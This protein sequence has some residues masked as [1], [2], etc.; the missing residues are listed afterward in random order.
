[1]CLSLSLYIYIYI[2]IGCTPALTWLINNHWILPCPTVSDPRTPAVINIKAD[3]DAKLS[4][5]SIASLTG[6][7]SEVCI[8]KVTNSGTAE[9]LADV[10]ISLS[11]NLLDMNL[12]YM[13]MV[14]LWLLNYRQ[15]PLYVKVCLSHSLL[16]YMYIAEPL[17]LLLLCRC[18]MTFTCL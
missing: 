13:I 8:A 15:T 10:F 14:I 16:C 11:C 5:N 18:T 6:Y 1:M 2:Y 3:Y 7:L 17:I 12:S 9:E 4:E